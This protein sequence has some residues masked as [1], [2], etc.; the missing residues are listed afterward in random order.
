MAEMFQYM[1]SL[2][3]AQGFAPL[4]PLFPSADPAQFPTPVSIKKLVLHDIYSSGLTNAISCLCR[5]NRQHP[6]TLTLRPA[7]RRTR[8]TAHLADVILTLVVRHV[9]DI[10]WMFVD[11]FL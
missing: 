10:Y 11:S 7:L 9:Y 4:P 3:A 8:P 1:Q 6:I 5:D 2:G